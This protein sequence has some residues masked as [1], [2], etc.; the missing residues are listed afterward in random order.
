MHTVSP[1][2]TG[3]YSTPVARIHK[4]CFCEHRVRVFFGIMASS[5]LTPRSE[6]AGSWGF[7]GGSDCKESACSAGDRVQSLAQEDP[8]EK[9]MAAHSRRMVSSTGQ[10]LDRSMDRACWARVCGIATSRTRLS[11][12]HSSTHNTHTHTHT[13]THGSSVFSFL[14]KLRAVLHRGCTNFH[15]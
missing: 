1:L 13:H 11:D 15:S 6:I 4:Q 3:V 2:R 9:R 7:P 5:E 14:R 12:Q 8:L 10:S